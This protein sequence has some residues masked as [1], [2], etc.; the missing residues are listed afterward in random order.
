MFAA[1]LL[2]ASLMTLDARLP[3][4]PPVNLVAQARV[5]AQAL[6]VRQDPAVKP[7]H[8]DHKWDGALAGALAGA[9]TGAVAGL[10]LYGRGD[11]EWGSQSEFLGGMTAWGALLGGVTG[12]VIDVIKR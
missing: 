11:G 3:V 2:I 4:Q 7:A 1:P 8:K 12:L 5:H 9:A 10:M 6:A